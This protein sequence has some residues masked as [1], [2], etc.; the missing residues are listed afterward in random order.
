MNA[1]ER[2][3]EQLERRHRWLMVVL[4]ALTALLLI[5]AA[6]RDHARTLQA[7]RFELVAANGQV[8]AILQADTDGAVSLNLLDSDGRTRVSMLHDT[9]QSGLM[10]RDAE[11]TVRI[12][13]AQ[14]AH[15]GGGVALHGE[16]SRGA[17]VMYMKDARGRFSLYDVDGK[18]TARLPEGLPE[19]DASR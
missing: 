4:L 12:G 17:T 19:G 7:E 2:R 9:E 18:E 14:F 10:I 1:I 8:R 15:G 11:D 16:D 6:T 13:V 3:L 5:A